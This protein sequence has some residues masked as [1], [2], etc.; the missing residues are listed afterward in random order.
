MG[1]GAV[2]YSVTFV[3]DPI[4]HTGSSLSCLQLDTPCWVAIHGGPA[5]LCIEMEEWTKV[6]VWGKGVAEGRWWEG[7]RGEEGGET[8]VL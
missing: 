6:G 3:W 5:L 7:L 2:S 4:P 8:T 1:A